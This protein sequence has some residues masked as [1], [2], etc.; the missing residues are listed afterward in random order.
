MLLLS[1]PWL[2]VARL[3]HAQPCPKE[4]ILFGGAKL[5][6]SS[7]EYEQYFVVSDDDLTR[8]TNFRYCVCCINWLGVYEH[9]RGFEATIFSPLSG[10]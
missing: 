10:A 3:A 5:N 7:D 8:V 6:G 9:F 1:L 4:T 2:E